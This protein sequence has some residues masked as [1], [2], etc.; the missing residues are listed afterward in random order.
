[1]NACGCGNAVITNKRR[2]AEWHRQ[3]Q[4]LTQ[5][6]AATLEAAYGRPST[7]IRTYVDEQFAI[8]RAY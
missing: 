4:P 7:P 6:D 5:A 3:I 1:M 2:H 8:E